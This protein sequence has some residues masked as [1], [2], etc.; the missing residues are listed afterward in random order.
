MYISNGLLMILCAGIFTLIPGA[1]I[2]AKILHKSK[3]NKLVKIVTAIILI[4]ISF[5]ICSSITLNPIFSGAASPIFEPTIS[6]IVGVYR[7][8]NSTELLQEKGYP[9][10]ISDDF[11]E[12]HNDKT[13]IARNMPDLLF[14]DFENAVNFSYVTGKGAWNIEFDYG[15]REW[16]LALQFSELNDKPSDQKTRLWLSGRKAP[17]ILYDIIGDPDSYQWVMYRKEW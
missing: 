11:V 10:L 15:N 7:L 1:L 17:F 13:F 4:A 5:L 6:D 8:Y 2:L 12:F 3:E 14:T 9:F 16:Y